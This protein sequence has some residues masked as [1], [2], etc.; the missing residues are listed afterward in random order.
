MKIVIDCRFWGVKHTGL[1]RYTQNLVESILKQDKKSEFYLIFSQEN[2]NKNIL[3]EFKNIKL[4]FSSAKHYSLKEQ[5]EIPKLLSKIK[6]DLVHFPHFNVPY[7]DKY[8]F[9]VTIHDLIKHYS[10]GLETT[11]KSPLTYFLKYLAYK[12]IFRNSVLKSRKIIVP[13]KAVK[14]EILKFYQVNENKIKVIYEGVDQGFLKEGKASD[15]KVIEKYEI[16]KPYFLYTGNVYPHK[17]VRRLIL[18]IKAVNN[19]KKLNLVIVSSRDVFLKR[20]E[21]LI[22]QFKA[23]DF[24]RM[25]G[26]VTDKD[27]KVLY[28]QAE[29]F[30][31]P[32]LM[33]GFGLPGLE[34]MA[35][36]CPIL[37]SSIPVFKEVYGNGA[38][39]FDPQNVDDIKNKIISF[40]KLSSKEKQFL[41]NKG[42]NQVKKYSWQKCA[43]KTLEAYF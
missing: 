40:L 10:R 33:E 19:H 41:V 13:S 12:Q 32:S 37:V 11:T 27:L 29:A 17:N 36:Q 2:T 3:N 20:I 7:F 28:S 35:S 34:A 24:V 43:R 42:K 4:V 5:I 16:K 21:K 38:I 9:V 31:N 1:G 39:Y 25:V 18:A 26:F 14:K 23:Q 15:P 8:P 30:I 22:S 6:P